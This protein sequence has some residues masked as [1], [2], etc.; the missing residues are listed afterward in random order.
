[1]DAGSYAEFLKTCPDF[2]VI[3]DRYVHLTGHL[4]RMP[5]E[6]QLAREVRS[7]V[8][9][10][11][12]VALRALHEDLPPNSR[13]RVPTARSLVCFLKRNWDRFEVRRGSVREKTY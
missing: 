13:L 6:E 12:S 9:S 3:D 10:A 5:T 1:M 8:S 11:R 7:R 2:T 4:S